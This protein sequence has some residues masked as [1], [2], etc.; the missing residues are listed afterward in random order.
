MLGAADALPQASGV[1]GAGKR[2]VTPFPGALAAER[3]ESRL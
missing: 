3:G 2:R 1:P